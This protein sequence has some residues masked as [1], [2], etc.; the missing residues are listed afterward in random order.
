MPPQWTVPLG[1]SAELIAEKHGI[2]RDTQDAYALAS[3]EKATTA[4]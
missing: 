3:H 1:E 2:S 4:W